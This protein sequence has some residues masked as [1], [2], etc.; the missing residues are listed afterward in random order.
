MNLIENLKWRYA[1]KKF[2]ADKKVPDEA[3]AFL[4]EAIQ[5]SASS[6]G[7]QLYKVLIIQDMELRE[8]LKAASWGQ[9]QIT[10]CSHLFVFCQYQKIKPEHIERF[11]ALKASL[12][13]LDVD[14]LKGYAAF[15]MG[16][17][18]EK[19]AA[20]LQNW[21]A[22]QTYLALGNLLAAC[23]ELRID[24]GPMEGFEP[25]KYNEILGLEEKGLTTFVIAAVGYR[26]VEDR[27]QFDKKV[28]KPLE[29]LFE[30]VSL[31]NYPAHQLMEI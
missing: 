22:R 7:L 9:P 10:D 20:E 24:A 19:S 12:Q 30:V 3:L 31:G 4:K 26:S 11:M 1:T 15:I 28:R 21:M 25:E 27:T 18:E 5:L 29:E 2:D 8:K 17:L 16:K 6:Y 13:N 14:S 23:A